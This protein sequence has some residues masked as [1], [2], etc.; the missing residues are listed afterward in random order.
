M[1]FFNVFLLLEGIYLYT[2][3]VSLHGN[4][5]VSQISQIFALIFPALIVGITVAI[6]YGTNDNPYGG[7]DV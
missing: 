1:F 3:I 4:K 2:T 7:E 5:D 6:G